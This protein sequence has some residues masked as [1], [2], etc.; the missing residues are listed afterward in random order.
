MRMIY[1]PKDSSDFQYYSSIL[2][3]NVAGALTKSGNNG[4]KQSNSFHTYDV[5]QVASTA[6]EWIE[7]V[8]PTN[9]PLV[10]TA[11][12]ASEAAK[13]DFA[14]DCDM[15]VIYWKGLQASPVADLRIDLTRKFNGFPLSNYREILDLVKP[16]KLFD[17]KK[18]IDV[19]CEL[20]DAVP[21]LA[22]HTVK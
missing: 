16:K 21:Q 6:A 9:I 11:A 14:M 17:P 7:G 20:Q 4:A 19:V 5:T 18:T 12:G 10:K 3:T 13:I 15:I 8:I 1:L 2:G 22:G